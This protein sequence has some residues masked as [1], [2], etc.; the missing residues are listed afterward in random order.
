M[1]ADGAAALSVVSGV[2]VVS[3]EAKNT[4]GKEIQ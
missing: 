1:I 4:I 2:D 3:M